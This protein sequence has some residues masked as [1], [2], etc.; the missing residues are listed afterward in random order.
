MEGAIHYGQY[1]DR[2]A[3]RVL[4][5]TYGICYYRR[6]ADLSDRKRLIASYMNPRKIYTV[7]TKTREPYIRVF[8]VSGTVKDS[9]STTE[10]HLAGELLPQKLGDTQIG[11]D[12]VTFDRHITDSKGKNAVLL[13]PQLPRLCRVSTY[14]GTLPPETAIDTTMKVYFKYKVNHI[15][16]KLAIEGSDHEIMMYA[17]DEGT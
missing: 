14:Y 13:M 8:H 4:Q 2:I 16:V 7:A 6:L 1:P 9:V 5:R 17:V 10:W 3:N 11:V 12:V 15:Q